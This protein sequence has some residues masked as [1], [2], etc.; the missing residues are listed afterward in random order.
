MK[1]SW[2]IS[3][4]PNWRMRFLPAFSL[5]GTQGFLSMSRWRLSRNFP[6]RWRS[7]VQE[8]LDR[9]FGLFQDGAQSSLGHIAGMI[10]NGGESASRRIVPDFMRPG[11]LTMETKAMS[12]EPRGDLTV[13]EAGEP[14]HHVLTIRG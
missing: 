10:G 4:L 9:D 5:S 3:T 1:A 8:R 11:S 12:A 13:L 14:A 6:A 7:R 2:G